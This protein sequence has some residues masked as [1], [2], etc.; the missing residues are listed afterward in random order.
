MRVGQPKNHRYQE[1]LRENYARAAK[2]AVQ[3]LV[4]ALPLQWL[5][6]LSCAALA[7]WS[8]TM[9]WLGFSVAFAVST[10]VYLIWKYWSELRAS[11]HYSVEHEYALA[12]LEI[13]SHSRDRFFMESD[14]TAPEHQAAVI[15]AAK[16]AALGEMAGGVAHEINT[17]L[18]I[19]RMTADSIDERAESIKP[20]ELRV[21][22]AMIGKTVDRI[23][24]IIVGLRQFTGNRENLPIR[25]TTI[26]AVIESALIFCR[27]RFRNRYVDLQFDA[28]AYE[29]LPELECRSVEVAQVLLNLLS[30]SYDAVHELD[31]KWIRIEAVEVGEYIE[32]SVTDSGRGLPQK[33]QEK[34]MQPF[35]TT[36]DVGKGTGL[37]LSVSK[38]IIEG[39]DGK[40]YL[41]NNHPRTRFVVRLPKKQKASKGIAA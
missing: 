33:V 24:R 10:P 27:E 1:V 20:E 13:S 5:V 18:A 22:V 3:F 37:G 40:L 19:I 31:E 16:L 9:M 32:I 35:Y 23:S 8:W 14:V 15:A 21:S 7:G 28:R 41:D 17:P 34:L 2:S 38:G 36:K 39:H 29:K 6:G 11:V 4:I 26:N 25:P 30:N 12:T